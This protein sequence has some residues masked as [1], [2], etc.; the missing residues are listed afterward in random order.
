MTY[1][2]GKIM[3]LVGLM[4]VLAALFA[5]MGL[6]DNEPSMGKEM[7]LLGIGGILFTLGWMLERS[8]AKS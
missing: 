1:W 6:I 7:M 3:E 4:I 8:A 5:G 2:A